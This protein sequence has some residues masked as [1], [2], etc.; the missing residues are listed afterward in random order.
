MWRS[1]LLAA[2]V[3]GCSYHP[4]A[5]PGDG[6]GDGDPASDSGNPCLGI[7]GF[8]I[9][10]APPT[11]PFDTGSSNDGLNTGTDPRC[12]PITPAGHPEVCVIAA[13]EVTIG[14]GTLFATGSRP[15]VMFSTGDIHVIGGIDV[16]SHVNGQAEGAGHDIDVCLPST[17][18]GDLAT[19]AG[20]GAGGSFVTKGGDGGAGANITTPDVAPNAIVTPGYLRGG[21]K[22]SDG[23]KGVGN[24]GGGNFGGGGVMLL[25]AT[26][27]VIDGFINASGAGG[28]PPPFGNGGGGGGGSGGMIVLSAPELTVPGRLIANGAG[29]ASGAGGG[30]GDAGGKGGDANLTNPTMPALGGMPMMGPGARG[31]NGS[32][33]AS[34]GSN[35]SS[36]NDGA[37]GGGGGLGVIRVLSGQ[38]TQPG[39]ISPTPTN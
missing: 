39:E 4:T 8:R 15:L 3:A 2:L 37:G 9:C 27:I 20:G 23:G 14:T 35:G 11:G 19:G 10:V 17:G 26:S 33:I 5:A 6:T 34:A 30:G 31:G 22:G 36:G 25:S 24:G 32:A 7:A 28:N 16:G 18:A 29:G 21:C 13:T 1:C 12:T 38:T